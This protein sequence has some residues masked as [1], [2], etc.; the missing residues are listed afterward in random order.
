MNFKESEYLVKG[1]FKIDEAKEIIYTLFS[2]K[3]KFHQQKN[4]SE[5][6][7]FGRIDQDS[8]KRIEELKTSREK[9]LS[10]LNSYSKQSIR[11]SCEV[12]IDQI[13]ER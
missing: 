10:A 7:R 9:I 3:I 6:E 8:V 4:F 12:K 11:I 1:N 13:D 5:E 2:D